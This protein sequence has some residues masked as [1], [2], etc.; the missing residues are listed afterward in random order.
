M[1][2]IHLMP[3]LTLVIVMSYCSLLF[4]VG[5]GKDTAGQRRCGGNSEEFLTSLEIWEDFTEEEP[6]SEGGG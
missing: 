6:E 5:K 2:Q 4:T 3:W 1:T